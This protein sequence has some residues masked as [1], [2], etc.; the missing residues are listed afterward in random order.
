MMNGSP[1]QG[2]VRFSLSD[3]ELF[4]AASH[5]RNPLH[6][7]KLYARNTPYGER[8][9]FG[10]LGGLAC[11]GRSLSAPLPL[12]LTTVSLEFLHPIYP[13]IDYSVET[14]EVSS[15]EVHVKL[16]D[17][18]RAILKTIFRFGEK[19]S[20][21]AAVASM[22]D[23]LAV[24]AHRAEAVDLCD[25]D[26]VVGYT[27][28]GAYA[29]SSVHLRQLIARVG[30]NWD[31]IDPAQVSALM[32]SSYLV[33]MELPGTRALF[34]RLQLDFGAPVAQSNS[35]LSY[36]AKI[37]SFDLRFALLKIGARISV[38]DSVVARAELRAFVR[39]HSPPLRK[40]NME[41]RRTSAVNLTDKVALVI[42]ASRGLG[43]A[44][45]LA[46]AAQGCAV[47][48]NF[49]RNKA[50]AEELKSLTNGSGR[51][52]LLQGDASN[53]RWCEK[54]KDIIIREQGKLDYLICNA[55]PPLRPL[56]IEASAARRIN[57]Y[58][59]QSLAL[60]SVPMAVFLETLAE[61]AG[62]NIVISSDAVQFA[63]PDWPHYVSAKWAIEGLTRVAAIEH[64][65]VRFLIVRPPK[66]AT[67]L[68]HTPFGR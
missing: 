63:P 58:V 3:L 21:T 39:P 48:V 45:A 8:V 27:V 24:T 57:D 31:E 34:S 42:G 64:E 23:D 30:L 49:W 20:A 18:R 66:L 43:A 25:E 35:P 38:G 26:L 47:F 13:G 62:R 5:D 28:G 67:D 52:A 40:I 68:L 65:R 1:H 50:K 61:S 33:G 56:R 53:L 17:G 51:V 59:A 2:P 55:C 29:P 22:P 37:I 4:S 46:L 32:L 10:I 54:M 7:S 44:I 36:E 15:Q 14:T 19:G 11:L 6:L 16:R 9:V 41:L 60:V 12:R